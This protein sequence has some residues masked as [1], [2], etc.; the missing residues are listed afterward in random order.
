MTVKLVLVLSIAIF[1][2]CAGKTSHTQTGEHSFEIIM[3]DNGI[4][5]MLNSSRLEQEWNN[6]AKKLCPRGY[7]VQTQTNIPERAFEP[8]KL[9]GKVT[10]K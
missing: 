2:G 7:T 3:V 10:C 8:G 5:N 9:T 4:M 6:E 1:S